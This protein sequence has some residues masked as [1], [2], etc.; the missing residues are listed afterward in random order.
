M[1]GARFLVIEND[2]NGFFL[3]RFD[4]RGNCVGDTW[5]VTIDDAINQALYEFETPPQNWVVLPA[6][7]DDV[8]KFGLNELARRAD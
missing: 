2:A 8:V 1:I 6:N 4:D 5:H 3:N 7:L